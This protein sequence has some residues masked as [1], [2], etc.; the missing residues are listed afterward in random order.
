MDCSVGVYCV[1]VCMFHLTTR[2][3]KEKAGWVMLI[4]LVPD[5][6]GLVRFHRFC[7]D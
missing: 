7:F 2:R 1:C 6:L 3:K 5:L 4:S